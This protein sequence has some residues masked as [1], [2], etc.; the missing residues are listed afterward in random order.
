MAECNKEVFER[1]R[2]VDLN[3]GLVYAARYNN[4]TVASLCLD[5]GADIN[6]QDDIPLGFVVLI[7]NIDVA[8]LL[9]NRGVV[10]DGNRLVLNRFFRKAVSDGYIEIVE[11]FLEHGVDGKE[12]IKD[13]DLFVLACSESNIGLVEWMIKNGVDVNAKGGDALK[14]TVLHGNSTKIVKMLLDAGVNV[15]LDVALK[16]AVE[17]NKNGIIK[18][19]E[20]AIK[21]MGG[22]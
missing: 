21:K 10:T 17:K 5:N 8:R 22:A 9:F 7:N 1:C 6:F 11:M 2:T 14:M 4:V 16:C 12:L 15:G 18:M 3:N 20:T 13:V 19:L